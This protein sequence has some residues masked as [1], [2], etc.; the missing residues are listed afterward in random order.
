MFDVALP[1]ER[2]KIAKKLIQLSLLP[3]HRQTILKVHFCRAFSGILPIIQRQ[4]GILG[5]QALLQKTV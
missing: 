1:M 4:L 2:G 5:E 3:P